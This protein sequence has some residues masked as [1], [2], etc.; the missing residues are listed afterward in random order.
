M[1]SMRYLVYAQA[2]GLM[3]A[4][5]D[6]DRLEVTG[7]VTPLM[8]NVGTNLSGGAHFAFS[9]TGLMAYLP[10]TLSGVDKVVAWVDR[11][12]KETIIRIRIPS[13]SMEVGVSRDERRAVRVNTQGPDRDVFVEDLDRR[14]VDA[15]DRRGRLRSQ[16]V[17]TANGR[18]VVYGAGLPN[19][20]LFWRAVDGSDEEVR[21]TTSPNRQRAGSFS[22]D[23]RTLAYVDWDPIRNADIWLV[24][25]TGDRTP[26][27]F[28][29]TPA[30]EG[31][32]HFSPDGQ[33]LAY[34]SNAS[35]QFE[36]YIA[37]L[38]N[39]AA[40]TQV[41]S[42]GGSD[43][44]W[45]GNGKELFYMGSDGM[46]V[47]SIEL[48]ARPVIGAAQTLFATRPYLSA[49]DLARDTGRFLMV[50]DNGQEAAGKAVFLVMHWFDELKS[51]VPAK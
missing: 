44:R 45:S 8:E 4:P 51:K 13:M 49:G 15:A 31:S 5:F 20:N 41:S 33:W 9:P 14:D 3:A 43:P 39:P 46:M 35:G 37:P 18:R 19:L 7:P 36:V 50:K 42:A 23:G 2:E 21:L 40:A 11:G 16:P 29:Q 6:L 24:P 30:S 34:T 32:P 1:R 25:T 38:A 26:R 17:L 12:G 48:G 47:K 27:P 10:G 22:P 28:L